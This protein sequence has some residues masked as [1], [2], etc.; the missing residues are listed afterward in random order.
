MKKK[1]RR[2]SGGG[3]ILITLAAVL[4]A[5]LLPRAF[6]KARYPVHYED[7][8]RSAAGVYGIPPALVAAIVNTESGYDRFAVSNVGAMGLMQ[9]M[10][11]TGEWIHKKLS[12]PEAFYDELLFEAEA[13]LAYGS[14]YLNFLLGRYGGEMYTAVAAYHAGQGTV[15]GWLKDERYSDNGISVSRFPDS[16]GATRHYVQKVRNAYEYY[17]KAYENR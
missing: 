13:S 15:D 3:L 14:W 8:I 9:I 7:E 4:I 10:P 17:S 5:F 2:K 11:S 1:R 16:A 6:E 12:R